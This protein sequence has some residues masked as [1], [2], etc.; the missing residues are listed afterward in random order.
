DH[1]K[2]VCKNIHLRTETKNTAITNLL[3]EKQVIRVPIA[4]ADG[5]YYAD[6]ATLKNLNENEQILFRYS[7]EGGDVS[8]RFNPNGSL[9]N[10]A[11]I[12]NANRNVFGM[13]PHPERC[14][15]ETLGNED[16]KA[17]FQSLVTYVQQ[18]ILV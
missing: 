4:H 9:E 13:M 15:E 6:D 10:I 12:C 2:F 5:R 8:E 14:A 7:S 17:L 11:G 1:H 3:Q 18:N 16:G